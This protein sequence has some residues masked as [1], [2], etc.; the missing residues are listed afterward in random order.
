MSGR[1]SVCIYHLSFA[2]TH[3]SFTLTTSKLI[4][5]IRSLYLVRMIGQLWKDEN[6]VVGMDLT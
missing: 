5:Q 2:F 1:V 3:H 4:R 6:I